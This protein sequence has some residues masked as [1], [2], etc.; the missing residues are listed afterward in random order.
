MS[1]L[2][3]PACLLKKSEVSQSGSS[4]QGVW[5][6]GTEGDDGGEEDLWRDLLNYRQRTSGPNVFIASSPPE[7]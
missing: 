4:E 3:L 7:L 2:S 1:G 5:D 6:T